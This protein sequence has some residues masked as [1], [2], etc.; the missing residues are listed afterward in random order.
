MTKIETLIQDYKDINDKINDKESFKLYYG[1]QR[2][3]L[4]EIKQE[5][6][7]FKIKELHEVWLLYY[8]SSGK[9]LLRGIKSSMLHQLITSLRWAIDSNIII[10]GC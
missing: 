6:S 2:S 4:E 7:T 8:T 3:I 9:S 5:C 1:K 10:Y